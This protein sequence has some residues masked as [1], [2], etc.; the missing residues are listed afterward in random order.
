MKTTNLW[1]FGLPLAL[2]AGLAGVQE[3]EPGERERDDSTDRVRAHYERVEAE[4]LRSDDS[5]LTEAQRAE[6]ARIIEEL[7]AYRERG[8]FV[9]SDDVD[10]RVPFYRDAGGRHCSVAHLLDVWG[11]DELL[12]RIVAES[13]NEWIAALADDPQ[14]KAWMHR[15]GLT[16]EEVARI[17]APVVPPTYDGPGDVVDPGA[18]G[19]DPAGPSS[20]GPTEPGPSGP[21]TPGPGP[22]NPGPGPLSG[23]PGGPGTP[24][25][26]GGGPTSGEFAGFI[27]P[28]DWALWWEFN[29]AGFLDRNLPGARSWGDE[30]VTASETRVETKRRELLPLIAAELED[31]DAQVRASAVVALARI[32]GDRAMPWIETALQDKNREVRQAALVALGAAAG[33]K[34]A[35]ALLEIAHTGVLSSAG[36]KSILPDAKAIAV[37]SLGLTQVR[38]PRLDMV[39]HVVEILG[40]AREQDDEELITAV[41]YYQSLAPSPKLAALVDNFSHILPTDE[42]DHGIVVRARAVEQ[43]DDRQDRET[44]VA[45]IETLS[46]RELTLRRSAAVALGGYEHPLALQPLMTAFELENEPTTRGLTLLAIAEQGGTKSRDFLVDTLEKSSSNLRPWS[47]IA[48]GLFARAEDDEVA[49]DAIRKGIA[50]EKNRESK[51][52][53]L[54]ALGLAEDMNALPILRHE[55]GSGSAEM[56]LYAA[57]GLAL[58]GD[59]AGCAPLRKALA[60]EKTPY[61]R[62]VMAQS[63]GSLGD[64]KDADALLDLLENLPHADLRAQIAVALGLNGSVEALDGLTARMAANELPSAARAGALDAVGMILGSEPGLVLTQVSSGANFTAFPNWMVRLLISHTV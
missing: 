27:S 18:T 28:A 46:G 41:L 54:L 62:V 11:E 60:K 7:R 3:Q 30:N 56:R 53:Y 9:Q 55:L 17:H 25:V 50:K 32:G 57:H 8:E 43:L 21:S 20:P 5:N 29:K 39:D 51:A 47:A 64:S 45:L 42:E 49:R 10:H 22:G 40:T 36:G 4:L 15:V 63:L 24:P 33:V 61:T 19:P 6:R 35:D 48:L 31:G 44:L 59:E 37:V 1:M 16:T 12:E 13:N 14:L 2:L 26:V 38:N 58:L 52:A 23:A 34:G